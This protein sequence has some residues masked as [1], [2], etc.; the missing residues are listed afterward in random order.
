MR[1]AELG[2]GD[3]R[4]DGRARSEQFRYASLAFEFGAGIAGCVL[5]GFWIDYSFGTG[6]IGV[7]VGALL[8]CVGG[9]YHLIT[10]ATRIE[11]RMRATRGRRKGSL[12]DRT[13]DSDNPPKD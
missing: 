7:I 9:M 11:R 8:G 4:P 12:D 1:G 3:E 6:H 10:Q 2:P 13:G 5:L